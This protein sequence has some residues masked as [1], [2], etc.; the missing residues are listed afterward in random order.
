M[1]SIRIES[2]TIGSLISM[3]LILRKMDLTLRKMIKHKINK[4]IEFQNIINNSCFN[5]YNYDDDDDDDKKYCIF[6]VREKEEE[7]EMLFQ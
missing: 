5:L 1:K 7:K 3:Y 2:N 4:L 6:E